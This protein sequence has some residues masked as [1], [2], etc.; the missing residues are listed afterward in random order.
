MLNCCIEVIKSKEGVGGGFLFRREVKMEFWKLE[1]ESFN[2]FKLMVKVEDLCW[3]LEEEKVYLSSRV[4][5]WFG[6][7]VLGFSMGLG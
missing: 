6:G 7:L 4:W 2:I 5:L 3:V 1:V